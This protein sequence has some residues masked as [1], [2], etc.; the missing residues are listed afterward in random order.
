MKPNE[1][2][3]YYG[4]SLRF[5][6]R[7]FFYPQPQAMVEAARW[8]FTQKEVEFKLKF[9]S[10]G[11]LVNLKSDMA[12]LQSYGW[13]PVKPNEK[14]IVVIGDWGTQIVLA[15]WW[16]LYMQGDPTGEHSERY[17]QDPKWFDKILA[18]NQDAWEWKKPT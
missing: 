1:K 5:G 8:V 15:G 7:Y 12:A 9:R 17:A 10:R 4:N 14:G 3:L 18:E 13:S 16:I 11:G 6:E 2:F